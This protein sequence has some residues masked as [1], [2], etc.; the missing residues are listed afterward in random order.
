[1]STARAL[2]RARRGTY[3]AGFRTLSLKAARAALEDQEYL[4]AT[5]SKIV[6]TRTRLTAALTGLGF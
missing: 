1:M 4:Q 3:P 5:R 2:S 6:A